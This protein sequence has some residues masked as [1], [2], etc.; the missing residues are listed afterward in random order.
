LDLRSTAG[1]NTLDVGKAAILNVLGSLYG[2]APEGKID[3]NNAGPPA[4]ADRLQAADPLHLAAQGSEAA[5]KAYKN[6][7]EAMVKFRTIRRTV[8]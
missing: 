5:N 2:A 3:F 8:V 6:L 7:A 4:I 1:P